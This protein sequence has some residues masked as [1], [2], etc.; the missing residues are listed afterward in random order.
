MVI[1]SSSVVAHLDAVR[2]TYGDDHSPPVLGGISLSAVAGE[3]TAILGPSA[4]GKSTL[5]KVLGGLDTAIQGHAYLG[6]VE[7]TGMDEEEVGPL[8]LRDVG[9]VWPLDLIP[10][11]DVISNLRLP[12]A[13]GGQLTQMARNVRADDLIA[14][15]GLQEH[16]LLYPH[17]LSAGEERRVSIARALASDPRLVLVDDPTDGLDA[18]STGEVLALLRA[19]TREFGPSIFMGTRD[20]FAASQADRV[21]FLQDGVVVR[22]ERGL[23]VEEVTRAMLE[24]EEAV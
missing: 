2:K 4:S 9:F 14:S 21:L 10:T 1:S 13:W 19:S 22:D 6:G 18:C 5:L 8:R 20:V 12:L 16:R 7:I 15:F 17:Q 11:L 24:I 3:L 23:P